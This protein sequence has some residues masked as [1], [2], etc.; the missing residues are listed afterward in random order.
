[1]PGLPYAGMWDIPGGHVE[2]GETPA[3]CIVRE[4]KEEIEIDLIDF[5]LFRVYEFDDRTEHVFWTKQPINI[6]TVTLNEGQDLGWFSE[7]EIEKTNLA[8]G[9]NRVASDFFKWGC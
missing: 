6:D 1:M 3:T 5:S 2:S 4:M 9:F 8:Y 7:E